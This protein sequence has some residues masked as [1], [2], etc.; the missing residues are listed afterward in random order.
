MGSSKL[1]GVAVLIAAIA[2][3]SHAGDVYRK[4]L[5]QWRTRHEAEIK[6]PDGWLSVSGLFWLK[7]GS[8]TAGSDPSSDI[9]LPRGPARA[10]VFE[11]RGGQATFRNAQGASQAVDE[12]KRVR[13]DNLWMT[14]IH[15]G[16]RF[17]VRLRDPASQRRRE[18]TGLRWFEPKESYRV[19]AKF[20]AYSKPKMIPITNVLGQTEPEASPG[21]VT[22][23][24]DGRA[25]RL[26][27]VSEDGRLFFIFRDLTAGHETYAAGRFLYASLPKDGEVELDFNKA[28]NPPCAFTDYATCPLPPKQNHLPLRIEAGELNYGH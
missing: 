14:V 11:L 3:E 6:A 21:Y 8:N 24:L 19:K 10:G 23:S 15:R 2:N 27:P 18:F 22:F 28:E 17:G 16:D 12:S 26:E 13:V 4:Q 7:E 20:V 25:L 1:A 5:E 9:V